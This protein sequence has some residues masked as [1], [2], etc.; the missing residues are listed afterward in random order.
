MRQFF[1]SVAVGLLACLTLTE[2]QFARDISFSQSA[3]TIDAFDFAGITLTVTNAK[4]QNPFTEAQVSGSFQFKNEKAIEVDGFCDASDGSKY[5]IRFMPSQPGEYTYSVKYRQGNFERA[6]SG[7]FTARDAERRGIV[8]VDKNYPW[9]FVW[10]GTGEHYFWNGTTSYWLM[11]WDDDTI[12]NSIDRLHTK[13]K[14]LTRGKRS[15]L[16][17]GPLPSH[18]R[19][20]TEEK[21]RRE[22]PSWCRHANGR[23]KS[24]RGSRPVSNLQ[25]AQA[26]PNIL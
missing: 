9:H 12:R 13:A 10:Q 1:S 24:R 11:G 3:H 17:R 18:P 4:I 14:D 26:L 25:N 23:A 7:S 22:L 15:H 20:T 5:R 2:A 8:R 6:H 16:R 21:S 19:E